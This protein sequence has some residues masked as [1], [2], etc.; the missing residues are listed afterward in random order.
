MPW[1]TTIYAMKYFLRTALTVAYILLTLLTSHAQ[2]SETY[3]NGIGSETIRDPAF[4][5][6]L[7]PISGTKLDISLDKKPYAHVIV[8]L[9][10][11]QKTTLCNTHSH[12]A[13]P[14][15]V[16]QIDLHKLESGTYWLDVWVNKKH[17]VRRLEVTTINGEYQAIALQ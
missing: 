7:T 16:Q 5:L 2:L 10:D 1:K 13:S 12:D 15:F 11:N 17:I 14:L 6:I 4:M 3:V 8:Q 9:R